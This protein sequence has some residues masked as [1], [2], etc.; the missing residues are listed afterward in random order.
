MES[1]TAKGIL[2]HFLS[3]GLT[4]DSEDAQTTM[5]VALVLRDESILPV[6]SQNLDCREDFNV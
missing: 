4:R 1:H 5:P 2:R 3:F 6:E